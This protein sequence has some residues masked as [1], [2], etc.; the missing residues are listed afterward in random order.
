MPT[1]G[2]KPKASPA[3]N[4]SEIDN[5]EKLQK[6]LAVQA[7]PNP[8]TLRELPYRNT[9][10]KMWDVSLL[11][12]CFA[13][14]LKSSPAVALLSPAFVFCGFF[15]S[16]YPAAT[17]LP[18]EASCMHYTWHLPVTIHICNHD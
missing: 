9:P 16:N 17:N 15:V 12:T 10:K 11:P 4:A 6:Q 5:V 8:P 14:I 13:E 3:S 2:V 7:P 18:V 1:A